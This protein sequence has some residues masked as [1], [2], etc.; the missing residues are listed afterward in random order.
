MVES[1]KKRLS[2]PFVLSALIVSFLVYSGAVRIKDR[3]PY[4]SLVP[5]EMATCMEC[6]IL[7]SPVRLSS[8]KSYVVSSAPF[9]SEC[10]LNEGRIK[11]SC[12]GCIRLLVPS[13]IVESLY[14]GK[15]YSNLSKG[16]IIEEGAVLS[17]MGKWNGKINMFCV[18]SVLSSEFEKSISGKIAFFRAKCR[19]SFKHLMYSW[20][21]A[22]GFILA[23]LS[24]SREYTDSDVSDSFRNAGLSHI[25]ALSGMHLS[26]FAG[27]AGCGGKIFGKKKSFYFRLSGILLFVWFAGLSPSLYRAMLCSLVCLASGAVSACETDMIA[28]LSLVFLFHSATVPSDIFSA[29]FMLSYGA[30]AGIL[31]FSGFFSRHLFCFM[32]LSLN[33]GFS[34]ST[35]AQTV[36]APVSLS[37]FGIFMPSG[38]MASVVV[39]PLVSVFFCTSIAFIII[40]IVFPILSPICCCII[41]AFYA[42]IIWCVKFFALF[43]RISL[44]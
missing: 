29:G 31:V 35:A 25:L 9:S 38:I 33:S 15:I 34:A 30:L 19:L 37:M 32:P 21:N 28:V 42:I 10:T 3:H 14:P 16:A 4:E 6:R 17:L 1:L 5:A 36:T 2:N 13:E 12:S 41:N 40:S 22:G 43:P 18:T 7:S 39:S 27:L 26:F 24:G 23:L 8:G 44:N 11:S 20:K